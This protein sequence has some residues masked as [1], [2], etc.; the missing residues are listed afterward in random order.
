MYIMC[1]SSPFPAAC[2]AL[3]VPDGGSVVQQTDGH[4]TTAMFTCGE[5]YTLKGQQ[6]LAC[7]NDGSWDYLQPVCGEQMETV[8]EISE[9]FK[10]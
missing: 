1:I 8:W 5:Y 3:G 4:T 2:S 6:A 7:R 9:K 10:K